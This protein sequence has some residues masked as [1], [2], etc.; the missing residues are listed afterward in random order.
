LAL[1]PTGL[2][3]TRALGTPQVNPTLLPA[4]LERVREQGAPAASTPESVALFE[5]TKT[6][7]GI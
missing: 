1:T 7:V 5:R 4:S 2:A 3:R 6:G